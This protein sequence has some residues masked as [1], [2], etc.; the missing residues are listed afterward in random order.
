MDCSSR[1]TV[2]VSRAPPFAQTGRNVSQNQQC[3]DWTHSPRGL[4]Y[5]PFQKIRDLESKTREGMASVARWARNE[6]HAPTERRHLEAGQIGKASVCNLGC[7]IGKTLDIPRRLEKELESS[8]FLHRTPQSPG[9][10]HTQTEQRARK[11]KVKRGKPGEI[12]R[13]HYSSTASHL[14]PFAAAAAESRLRC[15]QLAAFGGRTQPRAWHGI[16]RDK[17]K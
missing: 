8:Q 4:S 17:R 1:S 6:L 11:S 14:Q 12:S 15:R 9:F 7:I 13:C 2:S 5:T 10:V 3:P 16:H